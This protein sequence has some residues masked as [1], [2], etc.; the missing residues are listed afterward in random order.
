M[1]QDMNRM[2][3]EMSSYKLD[4]RR[5]DRYTFTSLKALNR[6]FSAWLPEEEIEDLVNEAKGGFKTR[7]G[8]SD[9]ETRLQF[10]KKCEYNLVRL[11]RSGAAA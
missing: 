2:T 1:V 11:L 4:E 3:G 5:T 8:C 6:Y 10:L 9:E 7:N